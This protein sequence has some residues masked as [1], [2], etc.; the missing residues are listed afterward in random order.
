MHM[1]TA[2]EFSSLLCDCAAF[3]TA[4]S[5]ATAPAEGTA[6]EE[7]AVFRPPDEI[8]RGLFPAAAVFVRTHPLASD[9][10]RAA[11][12]LTLSSVWLAGVSFPGVRPAIVQTAL[13]AA[14]AAATS[15]LLAAR[16]T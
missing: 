1:G 3:R 5:S 11:V 13:I 8:T 7:Q 10:L 9:A 12:L 6:P 15:R 16:S 4:P 2:T 14:V